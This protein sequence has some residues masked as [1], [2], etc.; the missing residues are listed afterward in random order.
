MRK[1][2]TLILIATVFFSCQKE[3]ITVSGMAD[4]HFFLYLD[5]QSLPVRVSGNTASN[6]MM[7]IIHGGPG[8]NAIEYRDNYVINNVETEF[9]IVYYDQRYAGGAQGNGGN[10]HISDFREDIKKLILLLKAKYGNEKKIYLFAHSWG[11]FLAPYFLIDGN[12]QNLVDGWIQVGGAHNYYLNDS[13]TKEML[14]YYGK[15]EIDAGRNTE[16]WEEVI[17]YCESHAY[18]ESYEVS[19]KLNT[20]AHEAEELIPEILQPDY[21]TPFFANNAPL[22]SFFINGMIS[23]YSG[24]DNPAYTEAITENLHKINTPV[25]LLWGK[26]DFVCPPEL[27][28]DIIQHISSHDISE[29]IFEFSGHSP[30]YNERDIFWQ[31]VIRWINER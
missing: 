2:I 6:K 23:A 3:K 8:G 12:N 25:L 30:M 9:A 22:I 10:Y 20:Y 27:K 7:L 24:I 4:D 26:Y 14:L 31:D 18:N 1:I 21:S 29:R 16:E 13:L 5:G 15:R 11:G 28:D 19:A 17:E